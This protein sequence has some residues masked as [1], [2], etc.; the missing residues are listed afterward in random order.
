MDGAVSEILGYQILDEKG[1]VIGRGEDEEE[2]RNA[3]LLSL[4][5]QESNGKLS[6]KV[7]LGRKLIG[8]KTVKVS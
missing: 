4:Y 1:V 3:A 2:A 8:K 6:K 7:K 5:L